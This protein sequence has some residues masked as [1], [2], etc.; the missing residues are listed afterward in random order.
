MPQ[1]SN[2]EKLTSR[3][4]KVVLP[5]NRKG[6]LYIKWGTPVQWGYV[7]PFERVMTKE[8]CKYFTACMP[9]SVT[10]RYSTQCAT[11]QYQNIGI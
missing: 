10:K 11:G 8:H 5:S 6:A 9:A 2:V 1:G 7:W 4:S 3:I